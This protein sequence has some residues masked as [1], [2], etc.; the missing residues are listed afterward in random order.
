VQKHIPY[1]SQNMS[2][3]VD[4][5]EEIITK[6]LSYQIVQEVL[7]SHDIDLEFFKNEYAISVLNYLIQVASGESQIG[8]C[9]VMHEFLKYLE[10]K[11]ITASQLYTLCSN[12]RNG[13]CETLFEKEVMTHQLYNDIVYIFDHNF[14]GVI[15]IFSD[16]ISTE[17]HQKTI[18]LNEYERA[19]NEPAMVSK[20]DLTGNII[21]VNERFCRV[22]GY[23]ESDLLGQNHA[24]L[25][26]PQTSKKQLDDIWQT[27]ESKKVWRGE[28]KSLKQNKKAFVTQAVIVPVLNKEKQVH[29]YIAIYF[30]ITKQVINRLKLEESLKQNLELSAQNAEMEAKKLTQD[31]AIAQQIKKA[32]AELHLENVQKSKEDYEELAQIHDEEMS[33]YAEQLEYQQLKYETELYEKT[34]LSQEEQRIL[35]LEKDKERLEAVDEAKS[36]FLV[37]FTHELKTPLNAVINYGKYLARFMRK[38]DLKMKDDLLGIINDLIKNGEDMLEN[39]V[40]ILEVSRLQAGKMNIAS[41]AF[42]IDETIEMVIQKLGST[43]EQSNVD[44]TRN[45]LHSYTIN[46]D[47]KIFE[48]I[49]SNF[50]SNACKYGKDK[51]VITMDEKKSENETKLFITVEDNGSGIEDKEGVFN[52]FDQGEKDSY[53]RQSKGTGVGLYYVK[54]ACDSLDVGLKLDDSELGGAK[55]TLEFLIS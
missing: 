24:L 15:T 6:W 29:E 12:F 38:S 23:Q 21:Q 42:D 53:T 3:L 7:A 32:Q 20:S 4:N 27:I 30:D 51:I 52:L 43:I 13:M 37:V 11:E 17:L 2:L 28:L 34:A 5:Q 46:S 50:I 1:L 31:L 14:T 35:Q 22:S 9:P 18:V 16:I 10:T 19:L 49:F 48:R 55:F 36:N 26:H 33:N 25:R 8:D 47:A 44:V 39:I 54:I 45:L 40:D 41:R